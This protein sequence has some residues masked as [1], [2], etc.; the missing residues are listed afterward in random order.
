MCHGFSS[1]C[2]VPIVEREGYVY[3][4]SVKSV[5]LYHYDLAEI[6]RD[7]LQHGHLN[8]SNRRARR[9]MNS[10]P[11]YDKPCEQFTMDEYKEAFC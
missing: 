6:G 11:V 2:S 3:I 10:G 1:A 8:M 5:L 4:A 9:R 7:F